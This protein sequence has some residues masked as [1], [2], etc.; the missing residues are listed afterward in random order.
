MDLPIDWVGR[1]R[2]QYGNDVEKLLS[3]FNEPPVTSVRKHPHKGESQH[4]SNPV[5]WHPNG[6]YLDERPVFTLDPAFHTGTY[7]VQE[8][9]SMFLR[10]AL[11][12]TV[13]LN[14]NLNVLD[15]C[16]APGGKSTLIL[17]ELNQNSLIVANEVVSSRV[18][19]LRHN[20]IKWGYPNAL[21]TNHHPSDFSELER[22]FDL[23]V[24]DAPCSGE[25]LFRKDP[26]AVKEWT[27]EHASQCAIRQ[28]HIM[29][30]AIPLLKSGGV[31]IYST[32]TFNPEENERNVERWL[33][34]YH[35]E[36]VEL[37]IP[38]T[39]GIK[40]G[41]FG[42]HFHPHSLMG[43]GFFLSVLRK[44]SADTTKNIK[45]K[46]L[47]NHTILNQKE[48]KDWINEDNPILFFK[49]PNDEIIAIPEQLIDRITF[50]ANTLQKRSVGISMGSIKGG[51]LVPAHELA[52]S[53][54]LNTSIPKIELEPEDALLFLKK[55]NFKYPEQAE[56]GW[57]L[58]SYKGWGLGWVKK[59]P[60]RLNNYLPNEL[61]IRM[62]I[63]E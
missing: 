10:E 17:S 29:D 60:N 7:Y 14:D 31:L 21:V 24:I 27:V 3:A 49:K 26:N 47:Q 35:L 52:Q 11:Q 16:A 22:F 45:V 50:V 12:Q 20:L 6:F 25:G 41:A 39:W 55:E 53:L 58:I 56:I 46:K 9:S 2:E 43:E 15:L 4:F 59:L 34:Q 33:N 44:N 40:T 19:A 48:L 37:R 57:N 54:L 1:I 38:D 5:P 32:C 51:S 42:Y 18:P 62:E 13:A 30:S 28:Q 61:R 23:V 63:P 8:A 36:L